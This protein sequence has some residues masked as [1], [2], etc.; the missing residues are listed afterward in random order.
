MAQ[1]PTL[2]GDQTMS[3]TNNPAEKPVNDGGNAPEPEPEPEEETVAAE[4]PANQGGGSD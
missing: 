2:Q 3:E 4:K 1:L